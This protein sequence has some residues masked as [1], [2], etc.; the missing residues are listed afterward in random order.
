MSLPSIERPSGGQ[1]FTACRAA[2][3][4]LC[5]PSADDTNKEINDLHQRESIPIRRAK[6]KKLKNAT[7]SLL[8]RI[9]V[10]RSRARVDSEQTRKERAQERKNSRADQK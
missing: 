7:L 4:L 3:A 5:I 10:R 2:C 6:T 8:I 9:N 1:I